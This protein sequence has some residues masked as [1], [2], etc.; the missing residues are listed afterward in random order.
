MLLLVSRFLKS[1]KQART[2]D[3]PAKR[4]KP[5]KVRPT[6]EHLEDRLVC[7][8]SDFSYPSGTWA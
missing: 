2:L 1:R 5:A 7:S 4:I 6:V 8:V 3:A